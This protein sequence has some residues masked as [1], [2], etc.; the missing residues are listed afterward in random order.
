M[1]AQRGVLISIFSRGELPFLNVVLNEHLASKEMSDSPQNSSI[2]FIKF[3]PFHLRGLWDSF[4]TNR[5]LILGFF[6]SWIKKKK[7]VY[8]KTLDRQE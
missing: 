7:S 5:K 1:G 8:F 4:Q 6:S 2:L 3:T